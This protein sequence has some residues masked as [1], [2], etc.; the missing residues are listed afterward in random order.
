MKKIFMENG[1]MKTL[2]KVQRAKNSAAKNN[3][4]WLFYMSKGKAKDSA[5]NGASL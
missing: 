5:G 3:I 4:F 2:R 1:C